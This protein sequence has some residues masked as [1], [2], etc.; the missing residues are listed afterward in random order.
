MCFCSMRVCMYVPYLRSFFFFFIRLYVTLCMQWTL[1]TKLRGSVKRASRQAGAFTVLERERE[2]NEEVIEDESPRVYIYIHLNGGGEIHPEV[3]EP[4]T[5]ETPFFH[6]YRFSR[7]LAGLLCP[8]SSRIP[9]CNHHRGLGQSFPYL[10]LFLL[11]PF[12]FLLE[13]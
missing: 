1:G 13:T 9:V 5:F 2:R 6:Y 11:F 4:G 3:F 12:S 7:S 8:L 10:A